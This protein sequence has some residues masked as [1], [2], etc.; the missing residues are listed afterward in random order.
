MEQ[1]RDLAATAD[2]AE[3]ARLASQNWT[4][5]DNGREYPLV[6]N[7]YNDLRTG[8]VVSDYKGHFSAG[9]PTLDVYWQ[10]RRASDVEDA[11][12]AGVKS[13]N[14]TM[15]EY[16]VRVGEFIKDSNCKL[17]SLTATT[18]SINVIIFADLPK[19][20]MHRLWQKHGL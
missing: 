8:Q 10:N 1:T 18:Y 7:S 13:S 5:G 15:T 17:Q 9:P 16:V 11:F 12:R 3:P 14:L 2:A 19:E 4:V 6:N 20:E